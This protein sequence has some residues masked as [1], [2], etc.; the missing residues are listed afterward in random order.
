MGRSS[1]TAIL[2]VGLFLLAHSVAHAQRAGESIRHA[3]ALLADACRLHGLLEATGAD[4]FTIRSDCRLES[5]TEELLEKLSCPNEIGQIGILMDDCILWYNRT[6]VGVRRDCHLAQDQAIVSTLSCAGRQLTL[7]E[8]SIACLL[9][10]GALELGGQPV[11]QPNWSAPPS[12][13]DPHRGFAPQG[14]QPGTW[15]N[16]PNLPA[17]RSSG[18]P[19]GSEGYGDPRQPSFR[20]PPAYGPTVPQFGTSQVPANQRGQIARAMLEL[21]LSQMSR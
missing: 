19:F 12:A 9:G 2:S 16:G 3:R 6:S 11:P 15:V 1:L 14:G 10:H 7:L 8:N 20:Q 13:Y 4:A 18:Y 21:M 17:P 5:A